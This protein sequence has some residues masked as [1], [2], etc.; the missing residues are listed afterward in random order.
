MTSR[1]RRAA[2]R[3]KRLLRRRWMR[4]AIASLVATPLV[5]V[6]ALV[7]TAVATP[8]PDAL[9]E[10]A[11][12]VSVVVADRDG[13]TLREVRTRGGDIESRV[14]LGELAP[15]VVP[16]LLA[17]EDARFFSHPGVDV[18]AIGRASVTS[19]LAGRVVSGASTITQQLA[20]TLAP[21]PRTLLGKWKEMALA[22]RLES[23]LD[24]RRILEEYLSRV[25]FGPGLRGIEA[26]SRHYLDKPASALD[27]AEAA[28]LV[29]LVRGPSLYDPRKREALVAR[30]RD[31]VLARMARRGLADPEAVARAVEEPMHVRR[32]FVESAA[33]HLSL[34]LARR[35]TPGDGGAALARV[36][37]TLDA[38]LER[39][40][41]TLARR[42]LSGVEKANVTAL[43]AVVL[44]NESGG[45]LAYVGSPDYFAAAGGAN[46]G[47][48]ALR[49]PGSTLKPFVYAAA[50]ESLGLTAATLLPDVDVV[51]DTDGGPFA[52][53]DYDG[54]T[55]GPVRLRQALGSSLNIPAIATAARVGP[56]RLL[57]LLHRVGFASLTAPAERYGAALALGD[58]E[59]RL[60]ELAEAYATLARGGVHSPSTAVRRAVHADGTRVETPRPVRTRVIDSRT[61]AVLTDILSDDAARSAAFGRGSALELP[62]P[63]AAKTGTSKGYRDNWT[64]GFTHE[65]TVAVWAGNFDGTPMIGSSGIAGAAPLFHDV[66]LAAMRGREPAP[67][68]DREGLVDVEVCAL[69]GERPGPGC[70]HRVH[71]LFRPEQAPRS[72][73]TMHVRRLVNSD[74]G[75]LASPA[76]TNVE[77][78]TFEAY[79]SR[80]VAWAKAAQRPLAPER[81]SP[82]CP[83]RGAA[84]SIAEPRATGALLEP[85]VRYPRD[86]ARFVVDRGGPSRQEIVL[87]AEPGEGG[88]PVRFVLDGRTLGTVSAPYELPWALAP[89]R[90]RFEVANATAREARAVTFDVEDGR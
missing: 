69:S 5:V 39:E 21:R 82:R 37:T 78:R 63:V 24:K 25:P 33:P 34:A 47:V 70:T 61:A 28:E 71:E 60:L 73:C 88:G 53:K 7:L 2:E 58:G 55:H 9:R 15:A 31:R 32:P 6:C 79:E 20:R 43:A 27:L 29:A 68:V 65:V 12:E 19:L 26:A 10:S 45:V 64:V 23:A 40:V 52:P 67:L 30:R 77:E 62:F 90:H 50:M 35:T 72:E 83:P 76:C 4:R 44:D 48:R 17:A 49:Q 81:Y 38:G 42:A 46:D 14:R 75:L 57:E 41:E 84:S 59:V 89:G 3:A 1:L 85:A 51:F 8:L 16:A 54:R 86:G 74:D 36:D 18:L 13:R 22:L 56:P 11:Q 87:A 80:Y 66:M